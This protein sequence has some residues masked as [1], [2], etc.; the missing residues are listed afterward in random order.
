MSG[1]ELLERLHNAGHRL[2]AI[3][4][5]GDSDVQIAVQAMKAG[6]SDFIEKPVGRTELLD[7]VARAL[8]QSRDTNKLTAWQ[9]AAA[10][11]IAGLTQRQRQIMDL[12]LAGHPSKNIAADLGISQRTV[13]NHRASIMA[14]TGAKS[15]PALARLAVAAAKPSPDLGKTTF[16]S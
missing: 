5:T 16:D 9:E 8:E 3:M 4:M 7:S 14:R 12:V 10:H 13:E 11:N 2:P 15:L 6:A 1:L